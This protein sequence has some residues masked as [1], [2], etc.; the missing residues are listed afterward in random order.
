MLASLFKNVSIAI[1]AGL[2]W[3]NHTFTAWV[4]M[5]I[6]LVVVSSLTHARNEIK[7]IKK[8]YHTLWATAMPLV[9]LFLSHKLPWN[10]WP[11][12][13][14][15]MLTVSFAYV[16]LPDLNSFWKDH[17]FIGYRLLDKIEKEVEGEKNK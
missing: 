14:T 11:Q 15:V 10:T 4:W 13:V 6:L 17:K 1:G 2:M 12:L 8:V 3:M 16:M 5:L 9:P 7:F